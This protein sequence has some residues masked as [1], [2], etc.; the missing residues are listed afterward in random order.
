MSKGVPI[1]I[2]TRPYAW[3]IDDWHVFFIILTQGLNRQIRYTKRHFDYYVTKLPVR[4]MNIRLGSLPVGKWR[5]EDKELLEQLKDSLLQIIG[6]SVS[7]KA[8]IKSDR[9]WRNNI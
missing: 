3:R 7:E 1:L 9:Y 6:E 8:Y 5:D 4:I 2:R